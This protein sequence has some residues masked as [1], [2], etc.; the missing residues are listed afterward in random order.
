MKVVKTKR[1]LVEEHLIEKGSITSWEAIR[2]YK[3]TRL[4]A[5]IHPLRKCGWHISNVD[6]NVKDN[7]VV[8]KYVKYVYVSHPKK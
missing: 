4:S 1:K 6:L 3:C 2:L 7:G 8:I 5:I